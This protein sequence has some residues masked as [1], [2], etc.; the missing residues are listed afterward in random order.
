MVLLALVDARCRFIYINV[1]SPGRCND[2]AIFESS[3]LK[4][5]FQQCSLF[6]EMTRQISSVNVPVILLGD[7]AFKLDVH[8]MKPYPFCVNQP[9]NKKKFNFALSKCRRVVENAFGHL[10][11]R[12]RRVGKGLDNHM[13]NAKA[14]IKA[15]CVL[16]NFLNEENDEIN[17]RWIAAQQIEDQSRQWPEDE[18]NISGIFNTR[19]EEIR[20]AFVSHF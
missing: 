12:F 2:S 11:A 16:H 3:S 5:Q 10:K 7:S 18:P 19:A 1:G 4:R 6:K 8:L 13:I 17:E 20:Q 14:I 9:L 15:C